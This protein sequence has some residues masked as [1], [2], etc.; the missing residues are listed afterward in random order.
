MP[1]T[2]EHKD[3]LERIALN[4]YSSYSSGSGYI[5][6]YIVQDDTA[7]SRLLERIRLLLSKKDIEVVNL[8]LAAAGKD[9]IHGPVVV[10]PDSYRHE[11][12]KWFKENPF[13]LM[14]H[15]FEKLS[16]ENHD[17]LVKINKLAM[18]L[19]PVFGEPNSQV[20][21]TLSEKSGIAAVIC[22]SD[23]KASNAILK[24]LGYNARSAIR[25]FKV[26]EGEDGR[27]EKCS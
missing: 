15:K 20:P 21:A 6:I 25:G 11:K 12:P 13:L 7:K 16:P 22:E 14:L 24:R 4:L 8:D 27:W 10:G 18:Y 3:D 19:P 9:D 17:D 1:P 26:K 5:T 2:K 23:L